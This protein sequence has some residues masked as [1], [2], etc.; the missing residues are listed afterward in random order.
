MNIDSLKV[1]VEDARLDALEKGAVSAA[2]MITRLLGLIENYQTD[3]SLYAEAEASIN[4]QLRAVAPREK[5]LDAIS[6]IL[7][8][9]DKNL[10]EIT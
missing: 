7:S 9:L 2:N 5:Q 1:Q 8:Y 3:I 10:I 4:L 6:N